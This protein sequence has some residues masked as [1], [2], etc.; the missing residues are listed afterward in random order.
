MYYVRTH[1]VGKNVKAQKKHREKVRASIEILFKPKK[2]KT[3]E[4]NNINQAAR[5]PKVWC[6]N[7][8]TDQT[9]LSTDHTFCFKK[10]REP[11]KLRVGQNEIL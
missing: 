6:S 2:Q 1:C 3:K 4:T 9:F 11:I 8:P 7:R 10:Y 5:V